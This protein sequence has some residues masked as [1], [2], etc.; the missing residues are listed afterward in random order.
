MSGDSSASSYDAWHAS[1]EVN[2]GADDPWYQLVRRESICRATSPA[3]ESS[4]RLAPVEGASPAGWP[5]DRRRPPRSSRSTT[6]GS[7]SKRGGPTRGPRA[8]VELPG[9]TGDIQA[10]AHADASFDTVVSCETIEHVPDPVKAVS[11]LARVLRP[12]GRLFLTT[13]N[14]LGSLGLYRAYLRLR[15][16]RFTEVGQPINQL[17]LLPRTLSLKRGGP[18]CPAERIAARWVTV[19][20]LPGNPPRRSRDGSIFDL[21]LK[22][23]ALHVVVVARK[24]HH[25]D[26]QAPGW[27]SASSF[28]LVCGTKA[29]ACC[30]Q[31]LRPQV[32]DG[33]AGSDRHR[34]WHD[35]IRPDECDR[36]PFRL[37][38]LDAGSATGPRRQSQPRC[39]AGAG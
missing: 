31:N 10:I 7:P 1:L 39:L 9:E 17:T 24:H 15:G 5:R 29:L 33:S 27:T 14:Y 30:W 22:W 8:S 2:A 25:S 32:A 38:A 34:R 21:Q 28:R 18:G 11:E 12:G 6:P 26:S 4:W 19:S 23:F 36:V 13:P 35:R 37:C 16:R 20:W 3:G